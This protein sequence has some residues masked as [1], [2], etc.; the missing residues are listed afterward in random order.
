MMLPPG[1]QCRQMGYH[2]MDKL[3]LLLGD[4]HHVMPE[5]WA[6]MVL[7]LCSILCGMVIGLERQMKNKPAGLKTVTL[8]CVGSAVF[9]IASLLVGGG[10]GDPGRIAAQIIPG[11]GFL[12]AGAILREKGTIIGLTTGA[13]V[14][15]VAAI[16]MLI[17][18]GY[19][20][21]GMALTAVVLT[22]LIGVRFLECQLRHAC[23]ETTARIVFRPENG[24]TFLRILRVLDEACIPDRAWKTFMRGEMEVLDITYCH[25]HRDHRAFIL[26]LSE[27]PE[28]VE[29]EA[30]RSAKRKDE[31]ADHSPA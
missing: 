7:I 31:P 11:I 29:I 20:A 28:V 21:A 4:L 5:P 8:I 17:G 22:T 2:A 15:M 24:K 19:A 30:D 9:T 14:W 12:G 18:E 25:Y 10:R 1:M 26:D 13:T 3:W 27:L 16:G 23:Q 6:G